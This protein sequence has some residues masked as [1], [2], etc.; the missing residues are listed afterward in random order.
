[1]ISLFAYIRH[2]H[3]KVA[4]ALLLTSNFRIGSV[5]NHLT[6]CVS[7]V[8]YNSIRSPIMINQ[9]LAELRE[10]TFTDLVLWKNEK[11]TGAVVG[12]IALF[13]FLFGWM[14][15]TILTFACRVLQIAMV[16]YGAALKLDR[17]PVP[18]PDEVVEYVSAGIEHA[19]PHVVRFVAAATRILMWEDTYAS[20]RVLA[21][22]IFVGMVGNLF[23]GL[24][25]VFL[26]TVIVFAG[27][28][29]YQQHKE[30]I[31]AQIGQARSYV[32]DAMSSVPA[33]GAAKKT[34]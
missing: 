21:I 25:T 5:T 10:L 4:F 15:Y 34:Q 3:S 9:I 1:M 27:P 31:D 26:L 30:R 2:P 29:I 11:A 16:A 13:L 12:T 33:A 23:S 28:K 32:S 7:V 6:F 14:E 24:A 20:L 18:K 8:W 22:S 17:G 19:K